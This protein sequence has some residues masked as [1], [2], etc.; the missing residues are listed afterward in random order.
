LI[1]EGGIIKPDD[2]AELEKRAGLLTR[3]RSLKS[4]YHKAY[5]E[6]KTV[7]VDLEAV[8]QEVRD[9]KEMLLESFYGWFHTLAKYRG[10]ETEDFLASVA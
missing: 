4:A 3:L 2:C 1:K 7:K 10:Q 6:L 9:G 5:N 8:Q